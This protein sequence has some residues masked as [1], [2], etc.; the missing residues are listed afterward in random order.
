MKRPCSGGAV[1]YKTWTQ[2]GPQE[3]KKISWGWNIYAG[4]GAAIAKEAA[5]RLKLKFKE[6]VEAVSVGWYHG[7]FYVL[8]VKV[9]EG[10]RIKLPDVFEGFMVMRSKKE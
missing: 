9:K 1:D 5:R 2:L 8:G 10:V 7:D 3:R 4:E 6:K